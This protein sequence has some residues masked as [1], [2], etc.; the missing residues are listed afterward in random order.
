M[1][2]GIFDRV[3]SG[4]RDFAEAREVD[5]I[6]RED[7][8][9]RDFWEH[10]NH[11]FSIADER[12]TYR[13][14]HARDHDIRRAAN[15]NG[16]D[17][18]LDSDDPFL[19]FQPDEKAPLSPEDETELAEWQERQDSLDFYYTRQAELEEDTGYRDTPLGELIHRR[20]TRE[21]E[22]QGIKDYIEDDAKFEAFKSNLSAEIERVEA[23]Y[24]DDLNAFLLDEKAQRQATAT[25]FA[26]RQ[27][28]RGT[29]TETIA[30]DFI[31]GTGIKFDQEYRRTTSP[32]ETALEYEAA[33]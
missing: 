16:Q 17:K 9:A 8:K 23:L 3:R 32:H 7:F 12:L 22:D 14:K 2:R 24:P 13:E 20:M 1:I 33:M 21:F 11:V 30:A 25:Q 28:E 6:K 29:W 27:V 15:P 18:Y 31:D 4:L 26:K 5:A 19:I 10:L